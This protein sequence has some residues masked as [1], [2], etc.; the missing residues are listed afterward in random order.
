[1]VCYKAQSERLVT[2]VT[3]TTGTGVT[4]IAL[5]R[6]VGTAFISLTSVKTVMME[7]SMTITDVITTVNYKSAVTE[8]S[9]ALRPVTTALEMTMHYLAPAE[10]TASF[11]VVV[12]VLLI[13]ARAA[14]MGPIT[15]TQTL[16]PAVL[17]VKTPSVVMAFKIA[18]RGVISAEATMTMPSTAVEQTVKQRHVVT[19][20]KTLARLAMTARVTATSPLMLAE[21]VAPYPPVVTVSPM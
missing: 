18:E 3:P 19:A 20:F 15:L 13:L 17:A 1:M 11:Q 7:T 12:M 14:M 5:S 6:S 8:L 4:Q 10:R 16:T 21:Q 2:M 9:K